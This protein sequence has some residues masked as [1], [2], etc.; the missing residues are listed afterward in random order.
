[1][2][3]PR[4]PIRGQYS[5]CCTHASQ[6]EDSI[7]DVVPRPANQITVFWMLCPRQPIRG[8]YSGCCAYVS[9]SED[10]ILDVVPKPANQRTVFWMLCPCDQW[11]CPDEVQLLS[12][13]LRRLWTRTG[14][15]S[16]RM[17]QRTPRKITKIGTVVAQRVDVLSQSKVNLKIIYLLDSSILIVW[18]RLKGDDRENEIEDNLQTIDCMVSNLRLPGLMAKYFQPLCSN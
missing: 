8:Q 11:Q 7:L 17:G 4:Q 12:P 6:S 1:M 10:S 18:L 2:L 15:G 3:C 5:G 9:Q 16:W 14:R 13:E